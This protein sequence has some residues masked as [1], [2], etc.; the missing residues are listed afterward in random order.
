[1]APRTEYKVERL[2][3]PEYG[4]YGILMPVMDGKLYTAKDH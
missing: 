1:L 4:E 2:R 3:E